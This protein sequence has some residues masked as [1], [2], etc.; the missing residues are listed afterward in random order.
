[1]IKLARTRSEVDT[2]SGRW[3]LVPTMGALHAGHLRLVAEAKAR[4]DRVAVSIFVNPLQFNDPQ[5]YRTY[6]RDLEH[7]LELLRKAEVDL[8]FAPQASEFYPAGFTSRVE[9]TGP[10]VELW[11][12]KHRPGHFTGVTIVLTKLF[13]LIGP[14]LAFFGEKDFQQLR[15][16][17]QMVQ[18]LDFPVK[19]IRVATVR[20]IDGLAISSRNTFLDPLARKDAPLIYQALSVVNAAA[21]GGRT[22]VQGVSEAMEV[23]SWGSSLTPEYLAVVDPVLLTPLSDWVEG[24]RVIAAVRVSTESGKSVRLIDN[25]EIKS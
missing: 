2:G 11:E 8:V 6:P 24:A 17:E 22:V 16:V 14:E 20:E 15:V 21:I 18:D 9:L 7:D 4:C 5:D 12:G 1:M 19:I 3:G 13:H 25:M 23:L 10:L